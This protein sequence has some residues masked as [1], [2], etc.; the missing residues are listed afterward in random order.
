MCTG[1]PE[2]VSC[3]FFFLGKK[4]K[5]NSFV[6]LPGKQEEIYHR[7]GMVF[8]QISSKWEELFL[9]SKQTKPFQLQNVGD[10]GNLRTGNTGTQSHIQS[11]VNLRS[12]GIRAQKSH[13]HMFLQDTR[14]CLKEILRSLSWCSENLE[15]HIFIICECL[16]NLALEIFMYLFDRLPAICEL[17]K[18]AVTFKED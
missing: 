2:L 18:P 5:E 15:K 11:S 4:R 1:L 6:F 7:L 17:G 9:K 13:G 12:S 8:F 14:W 10:V 16:L 3:F